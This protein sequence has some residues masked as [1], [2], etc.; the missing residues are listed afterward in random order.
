MRQC[1]SLEFNQC[2][3]YGYALDLCT[4]VYHVLTQW[5]ETV[6]PA[7]SACNIPHNSD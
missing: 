6:Q 4:N 1:M 7:D 5:A 2:Y 3:L